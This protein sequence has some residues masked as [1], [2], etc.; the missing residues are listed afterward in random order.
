MNDFWLIFQTQDEE[1]D[2]TDEPKTTISNK[3]YERNEKFENFI[4]KCSISLIIVFLLFLGTYL[5]L[6]THAIIGLFVGGAFY[7]LHAALY[8]LV[9]IDAMGDKHVGGGLRFLGYVGYGAIWIALRT[10]FIVAFI[11][12]L[13]VAP[14]MFGFLGL[15]MMSTY[16]FVAGFWICVICLF[17]MTI[18]AHY[19][20]RRNCKDKNE[21]KWLYICFF[22]PIIGFIA[23]RR[24]K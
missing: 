1:I 8:T 7:A 21:K 12:F 13:F 20:V 18:T 14:S 9:F 6:W 19:S 23:Y 3:E 5:L 24:Y 2:I 11:G 15:L 4:W 22:V 17:I 16:L 10:P